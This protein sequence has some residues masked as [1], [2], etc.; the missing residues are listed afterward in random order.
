MT[1]IDNVDALIIASS[2]LLGAAEENEEEY[3][4][5]K[6]EYCD[7]ESVEVQ[8]FEVVDKRHAVGG[9]GWASLTLSA[10]AD[11]ADDAATI[12]FVAKHVGYYAKFMSKVREKEQPLCREL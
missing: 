6:E 8:L 10:T 4:I 1:Q 2:Y 3:S 12:I 7:Q 5:I 11:D 9:G